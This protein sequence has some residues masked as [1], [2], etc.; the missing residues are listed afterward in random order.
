[1]SRL[2][3]GLAACCLLL[4]L[5]CNPAS[6]FDPHRLDFTVLVDG[7]RSDLDWLAV[8]VLPGR[9]LDL[10]L[11]RAVRLSVDGRTIGGPSR[12]HLWQ[13]PGKVGV[14]RLRLSAGGQEMTLLALV[15]RPADLTE[16][17][18]LGGYRIGSYPSRALNGLPN[19]RPPRGF[20]EASEAM[21]DLP[22]SPHFRLGQFLSKQTA[23]WPRY[24]LLRPALLVTLERL[25]E[26]ANRL[27]W[28][29]DSFT[30]MSG[31]RT[32]WYNRAIGNRTL[33]SRHIYGGAADIFIDSA[34]A[35][36]LMD[37]LNRD[38]RSDKRDADL[39]Y[40]LVEEVKKRRDLPLPAGGLGSY[41]ATA[42]HGPFVHVDVRGFRARWGR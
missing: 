29:C 20:I 3:A 42:F 24:L 7:V 36:G 10:R 27:G 5:H 18:E 31:F 6:A 33:Y 16:G 8:P 19:Y 26:A 14:H 12:N 37:D 41:G 39:L 28:H 32:P 35:D 9:K 15:M 21:R 2:V 23:E 25:L 17:E 38:G 1:M 34:P 40:D 30:V 4:A 13:A 11:N 22:V